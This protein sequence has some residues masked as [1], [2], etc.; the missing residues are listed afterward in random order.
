[1]DSSEADIIEDSTMEL[2]CSPDND[3]TFQSSALTLHGGICGD[4]LKLAL[5]LP[6]ST[7]KVKLWGKDMSRDVSRKALC[8]YL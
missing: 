6:S 5:S 1:M 8:S 7:P 2:D 4:D 3:G